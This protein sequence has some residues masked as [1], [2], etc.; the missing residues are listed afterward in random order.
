MGFRRLTLLDFGE[1]R[2]SHGFEFTR[3]IQ[4]S[5]WLLWHI[6]QC[7][8]SLRSSGQCEITSLIQLQ[9][10]NSGWHCQRTRRPKYQDI[11]GLFIWDIALTL[12]QLNLPNYV[13]RPLLRSFNYSSEDLVKEFKKAKAENRIASLFEKI[14]LPFKESENVH[15]ST[16]DYEKTYECSSM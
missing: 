7:Y 12:K 11:S 9:M 6:F 8:F 1:S 13:V 16:S 14:G 2:R 4:T 10:P 5:S 3:Q 15:V